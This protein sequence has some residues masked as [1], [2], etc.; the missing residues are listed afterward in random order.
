MGIAR[1]AG[2]W[3]RQSKGMFFDRSGRHCAGAVIADFFPM[4]PLGAAM[5]ALPPADRVRADSRRPLA[6]TPPAALSPLLQ[7]WYTS[8]TIPAASRAGAAHWPAGAGPAVS[9]R[10]S[11]SV[12][13]GKGGVPSGGNCPRPAAHRTADGRT[14]ILQRKHG[15]VP[16]RHTCRLRT[17][18]RC[19]RIAQ[20]FL[21]SGERRQPGICRANMV[22]VT[23]GA[24]IAAE[25]VANPLHAV[26]SMK[27]AGGR[28]AGL[29]HGQGTTAIALCLCRTTIEP[30]SLSGDY[31]VEKRLPNL[32]RCPS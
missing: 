4:I 17:Q 7:L 14:A 18:R 27:C 21:I 26:M 8:E 2:R 28:Q 3:M 29:V 5:C 10:R 9:P 30:K 25:I 20:P 11:L 22:F 32:Y 23:V 13:A 16:V 15:K 31:Q 1:V 6:P 24:C 12:A 19:E